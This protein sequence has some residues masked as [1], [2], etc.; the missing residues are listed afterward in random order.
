MSGSAQ[1][2]KLGFLGRQDAVKRRLKGG[3]RKTR[4]GRS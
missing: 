3:G 4:V 1:K 2:G